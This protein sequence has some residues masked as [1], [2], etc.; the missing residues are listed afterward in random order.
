MPRKE[1]QSLVVCSSL[2]TLFVC[3]PARAG[4]QEP[5]VVRL[6]L[7]E[8]LK[9]ALDRNL[10][11]AV[12]RLNPEMQDVVLAGQRSIYR[13]ALTSTL[14]QGGVTQPP[15]SQL[16]LSSSNGA[17]E[18]STT[19][20]NAGIVQN[21]PRGGGS[22]QLALNNSRI[23][24]TSN[25]AFYN[26]QF[27]SYWSF[28][29][30]QPLLR[31]FRIDTPRQQL[32]ITKLNR[33][34]SDIQLRAAIT[35]TL[36]NVRNAYWDYVFAA[37]T[38]EVARQSLELAAKLVGD[39]QSRVQVGTMAAIDVVQAQAEQASRRQAVVV[40][41]SVRRTAE[42][43]LKRLIVSGADDP[44]WTATIDP[45]DRP[46]FEPEA[47][48]VDA[49]VRRAL[50]ERT[51]LAIAKTQV[52]ANDVTIKFLVDQTRPQADLVATYGLQGVGGPYLDR[53]NSGVLGS[54]VARV[55]PGGVTDTFSTLFRNRYPRWAVQAN[56]AYPL[57]LS[58]Q[59]AAVARARIQSSQTQ[60]QLKEVELQIA[61]DVTTAAIHVRSSAEAV[62]AAQAARELAEKKLEAEQSKFSV[63]MSTNYLVVLAQR[64]LADVSNGELRAV[65]D[66]RKA[67]VELERVQQTTLQSANVTIIR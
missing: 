22:L 13:P 24:S 32:Q 5:P 40:A 56:I 33:D 29:Y 47:V 60:V 26:P 61:S 46:A 30:T 4:Q 31:N 10:D 63:G 9:L 48:D 11:I 42:L 57:G 41:E 8:A 59:Q 62:Q 39:N 25:N 55:V 28:A 45:V 58:A 65:L 38:V 27:Q 16:Q 17:V 7:D 37:Q 20:Y 3:A 6:T 49:A 54:S 34:V 23:A 1:L 21:V 51:D 2:A 35:N 64:D 18:Q 14:G 53:I 12:Q 44:N 52:A 19:T 36:S 67:L 15:V 43:A 66:Y 50:A